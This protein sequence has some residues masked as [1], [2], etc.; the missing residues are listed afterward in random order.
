MDRR[1]K[2]I[3][4]V[5][6]VLLNFNTKAQVKYSIEA[7]TGK[8]DLVLVGDEYKLQKQVFE[9]F[10]SMQ[11]AALKDGI[12]IQIVSAYRSFERQNNIW[13]KKYKLNISEGLPPKAAINK[14]IE[15]STLPGTSRHHWGTDIDIIDGSKKQP[16][17]V[18]STKH[19]DKN[20]I[21]ADLKKW[22]DEN[23]QKFGFYLVYTNYKGRKGFK[24]EPW[25]YSYKKT[26]V[27]MLAQFRTI[28]FSSFINETNLEGYKFIAE[29]F[30]TKYINEQV[31]DINPK[32]K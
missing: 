7:L 17:D 18:L 29:N 3:L 20:G 22:M 14:I 19:F 9:A 10:N 28:N 13:N 16:K 5:L 12:Y 32:L 21:Y 11:Q 6:I 2:F 15:Y 23:A 25:H 8:G 4:V 31:L 1:H 24:Y 27:S 26:A 30:I